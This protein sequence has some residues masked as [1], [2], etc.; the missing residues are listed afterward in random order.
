MSDEPTPAATDTPPSKRLPPGER[1][2]QILQTL[3]TMLEQPQAERITTATLARKLQISEAALYRH[4]ASKAQIFDG[5]LDFIENSLFTAINQIIAKE[6]HGMTAAIHI[7][8]L[9]LRFAE[10]NPGMVRVMVGDALLLENKRLEQRMNLFFDKL[11][12]SL[13]QC[14]R[15]AAQAA[16]IA[17]PTTQAQILAAAV[18]DLLRGRLHRYVRS[19]F[20]RSPLEHLEET[21]NL[22][23]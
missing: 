21:L 4:F 19:G 10:R 16:A 15:P 9:L 17:S 14:L 12:A 7:V 13:R 8:T 2:L 11:E 18:C 1:R 20:R 6:G 22:L 3:V 5:L 23:L